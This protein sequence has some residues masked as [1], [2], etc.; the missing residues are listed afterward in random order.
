MQK[1]LTNFLYYSII[2]I[3]KREEG[4]PMKK[5]TKKLIKKM[6]LYIIANILLFGSFT[7]LFLYG[8]SISPTIIK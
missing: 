1:L 2:I 7:F 8:L 5:R 4:E 3:V 6:L